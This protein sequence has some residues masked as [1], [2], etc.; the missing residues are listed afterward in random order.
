GIP[1]LVS[2]Q[3]TFPVNGVAEA[4]D[5]HYAFTNAIIVLENGEQLSGAT[6]IIKNGKITAIGKNVSIPSDAGVIDCTGKYIYPSFVDM[7]SDYGI[8]VE[9][10]GVRR[11][12][13]LPAQLASSLNGSQGWNEALK[14]D[15]DAYRIVSANA[16]KA[17]ALRAAG[18]GTVLTHRRDGIARGT[19]AVVTLANEKENLTILKERASAHFSFSRG[20]SGQSYPSSLMGSIAL[21]R[22]THYDAQWY[23]NA[24]DAEGVNIT[25]QAWN[26]LK[27]L[28]QIFEANDKWNA[29][30]ADRVGDEFGIQ[31]IIKGGGNEYQRINEIKA[32]NASFILPLNFPDAYDVEDPEDARFISLGDMKHWELAPTNPAAFEKAGIKFYLTASDMRDPRQFLSALRKAIDHGLSEQAAIAALTKNPAEALGIYDKVG[33]LA[34]GKLANFIITSAPLFNNGTVILQNWV[35]GKKYGV[36][37]DAWMDN[38]GW[39]TV[40]LKGALNQQFNMEIAANNNV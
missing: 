12:F 19:G 37:E 14:A 6:M 25:L 27:N 35:Q 10:S 13:G 9:Q 30:R 38:K 3:P 7:Y 11:G 17:D 5:G 23:N 36:K 34:T 8:E 22:Q 31:Y 1:V 29:I 4:K 28:P 40:N 32:T 21:L 16:S 2:G 39:Y 24:K 20:T 18:F 33:S 26:D 15:V